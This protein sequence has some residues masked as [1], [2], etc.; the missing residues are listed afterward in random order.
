MCVVP[1]YIC[2]WFLQSLRKMYLWHFLISL[3]TLAL[4][5]RSLTITYLL[6]QSQTIFPF[7]AWTSNI[8][9]TQKIR[10]TAESLTSVQILQLWSLLAKA[11]LERRIIYQGQNCFWG[12]IIFRAI[13]HWVDWSNFSP[14]ALQILTQRHSLML[15][16]PS[17]P[18]KHILSS[19]PATV[20]QPK[21]A[22]LSLKA[23]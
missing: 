19:R 23:E 15:S 17:F 22:L 18:L 5:L 10:F 2:H 14:I 3:T 9:L 6:G 16:V 21:P 20:V 12:N 8:A 11:S 7:S 13:Q 1:S 4:L